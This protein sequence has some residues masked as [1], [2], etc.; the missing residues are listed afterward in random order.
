MHQTCSYCCLLSDECFRGGFEAFLGWDEYYVTRARQWFSFLRLKHVVFGLYILN[1][2][3]RHYETSYKYKYFTRRDYLWNEKRDAKNRYGRRKI[4]KMF[5]ACSYVRAP[6]SKRKIDE[7]G[8]R[9]RRVTF[10][11]AIRQ[12]S[13]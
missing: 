7:E 1:V 12:Q 13:E 2:R 11:S 4:K 8:T 6:R 9:N 3:I 10:S 5:S